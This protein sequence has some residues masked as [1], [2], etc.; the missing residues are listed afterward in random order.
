M[1]FSDREWILFAAGCYLGGLVFGTVSLV[2]TRRHS[3]WVM[4]AIM[5]LGYALQTVGL[6]MRGRAVGGCPLGNTFEILQFTSW[7]AITLCSHRSRS[8]R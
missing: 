6:A 5:A 4:Y 3:R 1:L 2:R 7:S 8:A